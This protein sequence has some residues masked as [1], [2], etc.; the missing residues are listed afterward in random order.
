M[1]VFEVGWGWGQPKKSV[2]KDEST[3]AYRRTLKDGGS[4][5]NV[6]FT[7]DADDTDAEQGHLFSQG[8]TMK[9]HGQEFKGFPMVHVT[10]SV[11]APF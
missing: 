9:L 6:L 3:G 4:R 5:S 2:E 8:C 11:S 1:N 7:D 10:P